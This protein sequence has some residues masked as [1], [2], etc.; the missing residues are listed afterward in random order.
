[1]ADVKDLDGEY[2]VEDRGDGATL[3]RHVEGG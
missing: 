3:K 2:T 1:M